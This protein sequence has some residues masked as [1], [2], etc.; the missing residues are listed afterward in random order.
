MAASAL[1]NDSSVVLKSTGTEAQPGYGNVWQT[2]GFTQFFKLTEI[3]ERNIGFESVAGTSFFTRD[4]Y[5]KGKINVSEA[6][7]STNLS[8]TATASI[9]FYLRL[10]AMIAEHDMQKKLDKGISG[11]I[12]YANNL[13]KMPEIDNLTVLGT[14]YLCYRN[15][16][17]AR[18]IKDFFKTGARIMAHYFDVEDINPEGPMCGLF[19]NHFNDSI[20]PDLAVAYPVKLNTRVLF[21][22]DTTGYDGY[23]IYVYPDHISTQI[24]GSYAGI[25]YAH[26]AL[27]WWIKDRS[28]TIKY[29]VVEQYLKGPANEPDT[30]R[31]I[32]KIYYTFY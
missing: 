5:M 17:D 32:T 16:T 4:T 12:T 13:E 2:D 22:T 20:K 27:K 24:T 14:S 10:F 31:W 15:K 25:K 6:A 7:D 19:F 28:K 26:N 23:E 21:A 9:P 11:F 29:P 30:A 18:D 3:G 1:R 8:V